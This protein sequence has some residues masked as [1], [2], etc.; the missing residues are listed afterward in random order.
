TLRVVPFPFTS[1]DRGAS[2]EIYHTSHFTYETNSPIRTMV[3]RTIKGESYLL[4]AY[5]CT[6]LVKLRVSDLQAGAKV[7][8]E[9]L[10]ELGRDSSSL[11]MIPYR[12]NGHDYLLVAN[13]LHGVMKLSADDLGQYPPVD[14]NGGDEEQIPVQRIKWLKGVL[15]M[16]GY[17]TNRAVMLFDGRE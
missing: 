15:Q 8:G 16:D 5:T 4:A 10:A 12:Q 13:T 1:A 6:P 11:G 2:I 9:T 14:E 7:T 17:D 3:A